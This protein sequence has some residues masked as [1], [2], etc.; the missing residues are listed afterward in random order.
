MGLAIRKP[1]RKRIKKYT[2][3]HVECAK[4]IKKAGETM[5]KSKKKSKQFLEEVGVLSI[6]V[7]SDSNQNTEDN[8]QELKYV[9]TDLIHSLSDAYRDNSM[10]REI[11][12]TTNIIESEGA[13]R[14]LLF[15]IAQQMSYNDVFKKIASDELKSPQYKE[16]RNLL[17]K[18]LKK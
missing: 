13:Y 10:Y 17:E 1:K 6:P 3:Q 11:D 18:V 14:C 2:D 8:F 4:A 15:F 7:F 12:A 5:A 16:I 9:V